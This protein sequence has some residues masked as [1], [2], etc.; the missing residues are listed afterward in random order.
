M[1]DYLKP[2]FLLYCSHARVHQVLVNDAKIHWVR[3]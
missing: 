2:W 3:P 1:W